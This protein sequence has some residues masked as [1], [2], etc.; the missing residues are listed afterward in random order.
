MKRIITSSF[1]LAV[2]AMFF[3]CS[4]SNSNNST[5]NKSALIASTSYFNQLNTTN[6]TITNVAL[7]E[8]CLDITLSSSGCNANNW[9][10]NLYSTSAFSST[11]IP[12]KDLKIQLVNNDA[13]LAVFQKTVSFSLVP[14][15]LNGQNE[16]TLK[17]AGWAAPVTYTY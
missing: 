9:Q 7:N 17:I 3:A 15:R 6:Y 10:M 13:C 8:D 11:A 5:C 1:C 4:E 14:Y 12:Q 16:I 2:L